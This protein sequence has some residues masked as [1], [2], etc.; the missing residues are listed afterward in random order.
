MTTPPNTPLPSTEDHLDLLREHLLGVFNYS[1]EQAKTLTADVPCER[2]AELPHPGAKHP[3][4]V[5]GHLAV[6]SGIGAAY[7]RG[8]AEGGLCDVPAAWMASCMAEPTA[9]RSIYGTREQLL[10][11]LSRVHAIYVE[12][13]NA[14]TPEIWKREYPNPDYRAFFPTLGAATFYF[15]AHHEQYHL[16][17]LSTWRRAA[18]FPPA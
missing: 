4:W 10:G 15:M 18:G 8:D 9:E 12:A 6:A 1:L 16:G 3:G 17:Q 7:L 2:F 13:L 14:A 5:L 11:E